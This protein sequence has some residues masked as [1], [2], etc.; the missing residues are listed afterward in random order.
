MMFTPDT[1]IAVHRQAPGRFLVA[2]RAGWQEAMTSLEDCARLVAAHS[3]DHADASENRRILE[4]MVPLVAGDAGL[5]HDIAT[6]P[7]RWMH[8]LSTYARAGMIN[9][10]PA[11]NEV[12]CD[13][14]S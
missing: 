7:E 9:R 5:D 6:D 8:N 10:A 4:V 2:C 3:G 1:M 13:V 14:L 12:V 11:C